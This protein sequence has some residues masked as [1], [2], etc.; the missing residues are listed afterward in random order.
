[1]S[2][3]VVNPAALTVTVVG[4]TTAT[5]GD[6]VTFAVSTFS[7]APPVVVKSWAFGDTSSVVSTSQTPITHQY[8]TAATYT[9]QATVSDALGRTATGAL[10]ITVNAAITTTTTTGLSV[11]LTCTAD[12]HGT[13]TPTA[14]NV[15]VSYNGTTLPSKKITKVDWDW[16]DGIA[17]LDT[18]SPVLTHPYDSAGTYTIFATVTAIISDDGTTSTKTS[19]KTVSVL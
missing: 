7:P 9:V 5:A 3:T 13:A 19:S 15:T 18:L 14:C 4:Q 11:S 17:N 10:T 2:I 8:T 6:T 12:K 1:V 16:G